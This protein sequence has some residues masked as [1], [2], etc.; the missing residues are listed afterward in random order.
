MMFKSTALANLHYLKKKT[1]ETKDEKT[2]P[3]T[4][5]C[6]TSRQEVL[7]Y[8]S[9]DFHQ[10]QESKPLVLSITDYE[11][12]MNNFCKSLQLWLSCNNWVQSITVS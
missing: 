3:L 1:K 4:I 5:G 2:N 8:T 11:C 10:A 12:K 9:A 6:S 7:M